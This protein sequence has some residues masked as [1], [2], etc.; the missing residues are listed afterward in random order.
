MADWDRRTTQ[1]RTKQ[2]DALV[3]AQ[4]VDVVGPFSPWWR[5][6]LKALGQTATSAGSLEGLQKLPAVGERDVCPDGDPAGAAALVVQAGE[7]GFALHAPGPVLRRALAS[8][9]VRPGSYR[10]VVEAD[11][12][13]T[14]FVWAG[15]GMRFPV[16]STR[17]DLDVIARA[18]ARLWQVL[19]LSSADVV[20]SALP[21]TP[22]AA[23][24]ALSLGALG[25]ATPLLQ[26]GDDP[27]AVEEALRLVPATVLALASTAARETLDELVDAGAELSSLKTVLLIG[28]PYD[29]ERAGVR[30]ALDRAGLPDSCLVLAAHVPDGH[31]LLWAECRQSAGRTGLHTYPDLE[32]VQLIDPE[33]GEASA[34]NGSPREVVITQL[35]MRGTALV[36][37]R[38]GD[39]ADSV[40][41]GAC[42]GCGRTVPR[43][44][45]LRSAALVVPQQL[46]TGTRAVDVRALAGAL[47]GR[48]DVEDWRVVLGPSSRDGADE[49]LVYVVPAENADPAELAV[50]V[51]RDLRVAAG[52]LP[53]QVLL[54][55]VGELPHQGVPLSRRVLLR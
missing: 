4:V 45:G 54:V 21:A 10:A 17:S 37:W 34:E 50:A 14:S 46:R 32:V 26:P 53:S 39:V 40:Q 36:R 20:V 18:G 15:L 30:A 19:G 24:Q 7:S 47:E 31:R 28:A 52:A 41:D 13:P 42:S 2:Q 35:G 5:A 8:R 12:R 11:T 9:L 49:V 48:A 27:V 23:A 29:D 3:R 25:A 16:A 44:T 33:S 38:T 55:D 22:T 43:V 51:A 1:Q 6:R